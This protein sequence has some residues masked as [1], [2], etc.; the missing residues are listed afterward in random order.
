M[1]LRD[2]NMERLRRVHKLGIPASALADTINAYRGTSFTGEG[3]RQILE[4]DK[5]SAEKMMLTQTHEQ[6]FVELK[7]EHCPAEVEEDVLEIE[8]DDSH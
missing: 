6:A 5:L 3:M 8:Q 1:D 7:K 2:D 4:F